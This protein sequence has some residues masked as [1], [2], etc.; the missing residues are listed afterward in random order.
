MQ[1]IMFSVD[2][3]QY[4]VQLLAPINPAPEPGANPLQRQEC[5]MRKP[6]AS[7]GDTF[8]GRV[9]LG[10]WSRPRYVVEP[11][12]E[13]S[14]R[15]RQSYTLVSHGMDIVHVFFDPSVPGLDRGRAIFK[16]ANRLL[17]V[18]GW[19]RVLADIIHLL[20][21]YIVSLSRL[22]M[23]ADFNL[24]ANG[25]H[26]L[27]FIR[28]YFAC[29][30]EECPSYLRHSSNR[31]RVHGQKNTYDDGRAPE[32]QH[33]TLS[34][35]TRESAVQTNLYNKSEELRTHDKPYIRAAWIGAG[36]NPA[37]VWR[38]EFSLNS[39]GVACC[40][41]DEN[42]IQ[43]LDPMAQ[44]FEQ[45]IG[46][47]FL[48]Y[49]AQYFAFHEYFAGDTRGIRSLP[50]AS[51]FELPEV[52]PMKPRSVNM[53]R[54]S[55]RTEIVCARLLSRILRDTAEMPSDIANAY[56]VVVRELKELGAVKNCATSGVLALDEM[57]I[58]MA[59]VLSKP[60]GHEVELPHVNAARARVH[61]IVSLAMASNTEELAAL[62]DTF[63]DILERFGIECDTPFNAKYMPK[64][65]KYL[66][67]NIP[68]PGLEEAE[69]QLEKAL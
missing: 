17:Y 23:C 9:P 43:E 61:R 46:G 41:W 48:S 3:C 37:D 19:P 47:V 58:S 59:C 63:S 66:G 62:K 35:G 55:G 10:A 31:Y 14:R 2:W 34:F 24:F 32:V 42:L 16:A 18:Q 1:N 8:I 51:L 28:R 30:T 68:K 60:Y 38:V 29:P 4:S 69:E 50:F 65:P 49:A 6:F 7:L 44:E 11:G 27:E 33:Q 25:V 45:M 20:S 15:F 54:N 40:K 22:D 5:P 36:L 13:H 52:L 26:P 56:R 57:L 53:T 12:K 67:E 39:R 64:Y 21:G